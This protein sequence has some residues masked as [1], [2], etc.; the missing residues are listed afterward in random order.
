MSDATQ[1]PQSL[2]IDTDVN[3]AICGRSLRGVAV[4]GE[5]PTCRTPVSVSLKNRETGKTPFQAPSGPGDLVTEDRPCIKCG[6]NLKNLPREGFCP[7]CRTPIPQSAPVTVIR[8][9]R[10]KEDRPCLICGYNIKGIQTEDNCPECG[11]PIAR[12]LRGF[13]LRYSAPEYLQTLRRGITIVEVSIL[14]QILFTVGTVVVT[15]VV[16]TSL[17][18]GAPP[19]KGAPP[20]GSGLGLAWEQTQQIAGM[21]IQ[22]LGLWGWWMFTSEDP[23]LTTQDP[24]HKARRFLRLFLTISAVLAMGGAIMVFIPQMRSQ[25]MG[26]AGGLPSIPGLSILLIVGILGLIAQLVGFIATMNYMA[27][28]SRRVP[29]AAIEQKVKRYRWLFPV[30][31]VFGCGIGGIIAFVMYIILL[32]E[33]RKRLKNLG[34]ASIFEGVNI[35]KV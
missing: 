6:K 9:E 14:L 12:S 8:G 28:L 35:I 31:Y 25:I 3:C 26:A 17:A 21:L 34:E 20:G 29:D 5:C 22:W 33:W 1:P 24:A 27:Y 19:A 23:G 32:E 10:V 11:T 7:E 30:L 16:R 15:I 18:G 13:L 4:S 2:Q